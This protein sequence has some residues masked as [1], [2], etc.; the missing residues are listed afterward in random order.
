MYSVE[1]S[2]MDKRIDA[3]VATVNDGSLEETGSAE[4]SAGKQ[5]VK[6]IQCGRIGSQQPEGMMNRTVRLPFVMLN[7]TF[8]PRHDILLIF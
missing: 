7:G 2:E 1:S 8:R 4:A 5:L 3:Q 6:L